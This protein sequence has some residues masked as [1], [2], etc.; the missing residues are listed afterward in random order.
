MRVTNK[1]D[2]VS[3]RAAKASTTGLAIPGATYTNVFAVPAI[4]AH[5]MSSLTTVKVLEVIFILVS[6]VNKHRHGRPIFVRPE[7]LDEQAEGAASAFFRLYQ[8]PRSPG[9]RD[10][11][12]SFRFLAPLRLR[13]RIPSLRICSNSDFSLRSR[14]AWSARVSQQRGVYVASP[15]L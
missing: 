7:H 14:M 3:S 12:K 11:P 10:Q 2:C 4:A 6:G 1:S 8:R 9:C 15:S 13:Q 5:K